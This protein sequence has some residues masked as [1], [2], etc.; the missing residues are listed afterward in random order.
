MIVHK[1]K[2]NAGP[3]LSNLMKNPKSTNLSE[4]VESIHTTS[5]S[6]STGYDI[7]RADLELF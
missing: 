4:T 5:Y 7:G 6:C 1:Q 2:L 3:D